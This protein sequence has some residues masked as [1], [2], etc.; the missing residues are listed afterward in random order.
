MARAGQDRIRG[1]PVAFSDSAYLATHPGFRDRVRIAMLT[2]A[3]DVGSETDDGSEYRRLRR[4]LAVNVQLDQAAYAERFAWVVAT[5]PAVTFASNDGDIQYTVNSH[6][7][8]MAG[9]SILAP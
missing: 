7:D 5:N 1:P 6:W 8:A 2:A 9:A 4:A 3:G